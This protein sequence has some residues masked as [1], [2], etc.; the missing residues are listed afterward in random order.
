MD[1]RWI[2]GLLFFHDFSR[3]H[4]KH[5][6]RFLR[7]F[8]GHSNTKGEYKTAF[9]SHIFQMLSWKW[10][11]ERATTSRGSTWVVGNDVDLL[12][13]SESH[14]VWWEATRLPTEKRQT[15]NKP[16]PTANAQNE[17]GSFVYNECTSSQCSQPSF[18][19]SFIHLF[20][21]P[22]H[23]KTLNRKTM[24]IGLGSQQTQC[25]RSSPRKEQQPAESLEVLRPTPQNRETG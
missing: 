1:G 14:Y 15:I 17:R 12:L 13:V 10:P 3:S 4:T 11:S 16:R 2:H 24:P 23:S 18:F 22:G 19:F 9:R 21:T 8:R 25:N 7:F 6:H 20:Y 5:Y